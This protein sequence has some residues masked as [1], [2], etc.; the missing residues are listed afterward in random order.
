ME[1]TFNGVSDTFSLSYDS[2]LWNLQLGRAGEYRGTI[3]KTFY[4]AEIHEDQLDYFIWVTD[5]CDEPAS[6]VWMTTDIPKL[7]EALKK[8]GIFPML[9]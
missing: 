8:E 9:D 2:N 4:F 7:M 3:T 6:K 1:G 5:D